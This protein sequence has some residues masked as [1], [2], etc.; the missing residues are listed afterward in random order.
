[1][2]RLSAAKYGTEATHVGGEALGVLQS[3]FVDTI[4]AKI[5][6]MREKL[7]KNLQ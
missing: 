4:E 2:K 3:A 6:E 5:N 7:K 1:M